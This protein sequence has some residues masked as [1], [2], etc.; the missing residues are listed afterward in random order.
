MLRSLFAGVTGLS[1]NIAELD[2]VGNNI[3]NVNTIGFK[4][5]RVTFQEILTQNV[6][7][8][9]RPSESGGL[10]G[11]NPQQIGLGT[12]VGSI[13]SEFQQG[14]LR[15]TGNKTDLA[16][17]G[18]G[19]FV[20][21]DGNSLSYSRAGNFAFD[22][23]NTLVNASTGLKVQGMLADDNGEFTSGAIQDIQIDPSTVMPAQPTSS[24]QVFG[25]LSSDS[26]AQGTHLVQAGPL[27]ATAVGAD[28]LATLHSGADGTDMN[29]GTG[30]EI[31]LTGKVG[32]V[33]LVDLRFE[34]GD[35]TT[36]ADGTTL[37]DLRA[38]FENEL[39]TAAGVGITVTINADGSMSIAN[40]AGGPMLEDI[41]LQVGGRVDFN[42]VM[43]FG[44]QIAPGDTGTSAATML[45]PATDTDVLDDLFNRDGQRLN[46]VFEDDPLVPG[47]R[48]TS[49]EIGGTL[50]NEAITPVVFEIEE[51]VTQLSELISRLEQ[52]FRISN[53]DGV[54]IG[55]DG[56]IDVQ[57][58][59][60]EAFGIDNISIREQDNL[61]SN[62]GTS[63][64]FTVIDEAKDADTYSVTSTVYD[65]LGNTHNLTLDFT[66]RTGLNIWD[67]QAKLDGDEEIT[68]GETG[69]VTFSEDG[70]LQSFLYTDGGGQ[71]S[72]RP[73][74][75]GT[76][77]AEPVSIVIDPG[78][79]GGVN[80]LTQYSQKDQIQSV[81][82]G[83]GVG[84]LIDFD[85]D[86]RGVVTGRF[87]NDTV[88]NMAR[89]SLASFNNPAALVRNGSNTYA[90]SGNSGQAVM[91]FAT[92]GSM[93]E[94]A[95]GAL[96][97]SN[98]DLSE[99]FTRLVVA[100]RAFQSN[101][102]VISTSDEVLQEL[103]NIV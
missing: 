102:R 30:D 29:L 79:I 84:R 70:R 99:Q 77:G 81:S 43:L 88:L 49:I 103:V 9:T 47:R 17:Q 21:S 75:Q 60:G 82:D 45:S 89:I 19:F 59:V 37:E 24:I 40:P 100:Q 95:A 36:G 46:F 62:L 10:G 12:I 86:R 13:D 44:N 83:F 18:D 63:L 65:S 78:T 23:N 97:A 48:V 52:A 32:G 71:I 64:D 27:L 85:I 58:D 31:G 72:F 73:Q 90:V 93:G 50:G 94:L 96:E 20:L 11:V 92:E 22:A 61:F 3:S 1:A 33:D 87:S 57:G 42:Q 98:V 4:S 28:E 76:Q 69:T 8:A 67:W 74:A 41:K 80:G 16:I 68:A 5:A 101:A 53:S 25:N 38:W 14:N 7:S 35:P 66:K 39:T 6:R 2:V 15:T 26:D 51:N 55:A 54:S 34:I 56:R 91:G